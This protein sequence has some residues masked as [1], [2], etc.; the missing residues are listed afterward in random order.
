MASNLD[1]IFERWKAALT[2]KNRSHEFI[3]SNFDELWDA[4]KSA[5]ATLDQARAF[6]PLAIKA[7]QPSS[8]TAKY[9]W[10]NVKRDP[11]FAGITESEFTADWNKDIADRA[12]NSLYV[13]FPI[14]ETPDD[15]GEPK[16]YS[17]MSAREYALQRAHADS[18][19]MIDMEEVTENDVLSE[20]EMLKALEEAD[21]DTAS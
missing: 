11:K 13:F 20:E 8:S 3:N 17:K 4:L 2:T 12:T 9:T 14:P 18:F 10:N 6:L 21:E 1:L 19:E 16:V 5:N 7:H 15:D